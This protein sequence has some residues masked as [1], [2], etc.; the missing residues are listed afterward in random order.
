MT[1]TDDLPGGFRRGLEQLPTWEPAGFEAA[2]GQ[3]AVGKMVRRR[4]LAV[5]GSAA[6]VLAL[7]GGGIGVST[8]MSGRTEAPSAVLAAASGS[9][10]QP[11]STTN[12]A[13]KSPKDEAATKEAAAK[14]AAAKDQAAKDSAAAR[15]AAK[16]AAKPD[17]APQTDADRA[18]VGVLPHGQSQLPD[19]LAYVRQQGGTGPLVREL[20]PFDEAGPQLAVIAGT[21]GEGDPAVQPVTGANDFLTLPDHRQPSGDPAVDGVVAVAQF[22][23][24]ADAQA[25]VTDA[26][27]PTGGRSFAWS[28]NLK[29]IAVPGLTDHGVRVFSSTNRYVPIGGDGSWVH[30]PALTAFAVS[31]NWIVSVQ[32]DA[33]GQADPQQ[34]L[35]TLMNAMTGNLA[36]SGLVR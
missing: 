9:S 33:S 20:T 28:D 30:Y 26:L 8:L 24:H 10:S 14:E 3:R 2:V 23:S 11:L 6:L 25:A 34:A 12:V 19:G 5:A 22:A 32:L 13:P 35:T 4:Q 31:G 29:E 17:P 36:T 16:P 1:N 21:V 27:S 18:V 7:V 15:K